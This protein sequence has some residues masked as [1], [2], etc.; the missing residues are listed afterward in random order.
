MHDF[1]TD[2]EWEKPEPVLKRLLVISVVILVISG[3]ILVISGVTVVFA[4]ERSKY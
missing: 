1:R 4:T 2:T 3:V